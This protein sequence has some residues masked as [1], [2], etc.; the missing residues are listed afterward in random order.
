MPRFTRESTPLT[1]REIRKAARAAVSALEENNLNCCL[2]GSAACAI[3]GMDRE[4]NV[5]Q[6]EPGL[7]ISLG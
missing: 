4:P 1:G 5:S 3:Y 2:F 7:Q 6:S